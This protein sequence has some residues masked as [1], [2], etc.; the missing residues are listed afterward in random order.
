VKIIVAGKDETAVLGSQIKQLALQRKVLHKPKWI[1]PDIS[2]VSLEKAKTEKEYLDK[3]VR[4]AFYR[5][6]VGINRINFSRRKG[7][8]GFLVYKFR[9]ILWRVLRY[10]YDA[11]FYRQNAVNN[12]FT[13]LHEFEVNEFQKEIQSLKERII[14]LEHKKAE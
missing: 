14:K 6:G 3:L 11:I 1:S 4:L 9:R 7:C 8:F 10:Q 12:V 2:A 5:D 13:S